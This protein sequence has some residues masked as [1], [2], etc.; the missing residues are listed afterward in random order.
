MAEGSARG[1]FRLFSLSKK[2]DKAS[3]PIATLIKS[4]SET[5]NWVSFGCTHE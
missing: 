3:L 1:M 2:G 4:S 5:T